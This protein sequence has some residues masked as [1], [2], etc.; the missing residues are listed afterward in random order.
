MFA[1]VEWLDG[2]EVSVVP[3]SWIVSADGVTFSYWPPNKL[4]A[5]AKDCIIRKQSSPELDWQRY[6][7][8]V[9]RTEGNFGHAAY[10]CSHCNLKLDILNQRSLFTAGIVILYNDDVMCANSLLVLNFSICR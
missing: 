5:K 10:H 9:I 1:I 2:N 8:R 4:S 7:V 6:S 3:L